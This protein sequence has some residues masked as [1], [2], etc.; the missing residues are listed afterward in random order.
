MLCGA[1]LFHDKLCV[2]FRPWSTV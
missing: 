2:C 1:S